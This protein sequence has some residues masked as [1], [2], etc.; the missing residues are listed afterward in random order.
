MEKGHEA[1]VLLQERET[2]TSQSQVEE[3]AKYQVSDAE[4]GSITKKMI[5][6][7]GGV[8]YSAAGCPASVRIPIRTEQRFWGSCESLL[9]ET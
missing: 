6:R 7:C 8:L 3:T 5:S 9:S 4:G 1:A 2:A